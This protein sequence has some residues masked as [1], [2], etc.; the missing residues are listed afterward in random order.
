MIRVLRRRSVVRFV[1]WAVGIALTASMSAARAEGAFAQL[2][3]ARPPAGSSF[4]RVVNPG[5]APLRVRIAD[6]PAQTLAGERMASTYAIVRANL[7]FSVV[8]DGKVFKRQVAPDTFTTLVAKRE[9]DHRSLQA[10]DDTGAAQDAL[11][12]D[13]RFYSL[14]Q[15]CEGRLDVAGAGGPTL[16]PSVAAYSAA[17]RGIRPVAAAL[18]ASCGASQS[19]TYK[20]PALQPG[21]HYSLFLT[22]SAAAPVLRGQLSEVDPYRQ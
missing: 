20:L 17:G 21:D 16:F 7:P 8:L 4:V 14:V 2:Y 11:K 5:D 13:L 18:S 9:G 6:G 1:A 10:I 3:A 15:G 19:A 12:A 22:G